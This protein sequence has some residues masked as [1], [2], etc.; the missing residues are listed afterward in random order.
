MKRNWTPSSLV[1]WHDV[2]GKRKSFK[3]SAPVIVWTEPDRSEELNVVIVVP[4]NPSGAGV[5]DL[6][7]WTARE[8]L[9]VS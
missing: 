3:A 1:R 7:R 2:A 8:R 6:S 9:S 4:K 5:I